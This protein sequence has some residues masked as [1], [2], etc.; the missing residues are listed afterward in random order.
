MDVPGHE[1]LVH[2]MVAGATGIDYA[3]LIV[4]ADDGIMPQTL[5]HVAILSLLGLEQGCVVITKKDRADANQISQLQSD[6]S[7]LLQN[8]FLA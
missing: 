6:L 8:G 3:M 2:T 1:N 7:N 4:A 5:E